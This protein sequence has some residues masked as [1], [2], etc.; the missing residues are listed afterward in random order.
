MQWSMEICCGNRELLLLCVFILA[1]EPNHL[2]NTAGEW[3]ILKL[4]PVLFSWWEVFSARVFFGKIA[5]CLGNNVF[6]VYFSEAKRGHYDPIYNTT[7]QSSA[8][9][10]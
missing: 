2:L 10:P 1:G 5:K 3:F 6:I 7:L 4:P 8:C 9:Y